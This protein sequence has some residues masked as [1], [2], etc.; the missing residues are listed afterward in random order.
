MEGYFVLFRETCFLN[1]WATWCGPC[2]SEL[3]TIEEV[4]R[5]F[6]NEIVFLIA[7]DEDPTKIQNYISENKFDL[8][9]IHLDI[10]YIDAYIVKLAT[11]FLVDRNGQLVSQEEGFRIWTQAGNVERLKK[12]VKKL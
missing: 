2:K 7:S 12:L 11:T 5:Q 9:F 10:P 6:K 8:H 3:E 1:F 4:F